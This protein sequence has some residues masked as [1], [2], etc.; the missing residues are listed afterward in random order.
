MTTQNNGNSKPSLIQRIR[1]T[2]SRT[3]SDSPASTLI[4]STSEEKDVDT[5]AS[6]DLEKTASRASN[7]LP[8]PPPPLGQGGPLPSDADEAP[9]APGEPE[10]FFYPEGGRDAW[11]VVFGAF[12][13]MIGGFSLMNSVGVI[14]DY[15]QQNQL[16]DYSPSTVGWI[17]SIY[18]FFIYFGGLQ[19][20]P[21]F[22][23]YGPRWCMVAGSIIMVVMFFTLAE[24]TQYWHFILDLGIFGGIGSSLLFT[25][26]MG[27]VAHWFD[28]KRGNA[29]GLA[30]TGGAVGGVIFPLMLERL[31]PMVGWAWSMRILGFI[32]LFICTI[33]VILTRSR[34]PPKAGGTVL[35]D[36]RIFNDG[37][38]ALALVTFGTWFIEWGLF[39]PLSYVP[40]YAA[41]NG[42]TNGFQILAILNGCSFFGRWAPGWVADHIGR[43]NTMLI[44]SSACLIVVLAFWL[45][46]G[47]SFGD[48][49]VTQPLLITF[50][51]FFGFF[52]GSNISITPICV[53]QLCEIQDYG[54]YYATVYT[55]VAIGSLTGLPIAGAIINACGG[56]FY[57]VVIFCGLCYV[58]AFLAFAAARVRKVGWSLTAKW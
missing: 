41:A 8:L 28:K 50:A 19:I 34:L 24:A 58:F 9:N 26:C 51:V 14:Q 57:G 17:F 10:V 55:T 54:R 35:P 47:R 13:G 38:G 7:T 53:G 40:E 52:S 33:A 20:G 12:C 11:L 1:E 27:A 43:F 36:F 32:Y 2:F 23:K 48:G 25:P 46:A 44:T 5:P 6:A 16:R 15:V 4:P 56:E 18:L 30:A 42:L 45:P 21:V 31:F 39:I 29:T 49:A 22:D 37:T 3:P